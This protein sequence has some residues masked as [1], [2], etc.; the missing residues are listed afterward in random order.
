MSRNYWTHWAIAV[1]IAAAP[2]GGFAQ[3]PAPV[4]E[5]AE[6]P[7]YYEFFLKQG[8]QKR[9]AAE[10]AR[11]EAIETGDLTPVAMNE[12]VPDFELPDGFGNTIGLRDYVGK[13]NVVLTTFRTWW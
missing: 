4:E 12:P 5:V 6:L 3:D 11:D 7:G 2:G 13:K 10:R 9:I 8:S 1:A